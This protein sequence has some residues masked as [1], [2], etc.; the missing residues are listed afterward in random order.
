VSI[1]YNRTVVP[2]A[3]TQ[4]KNVISILVTT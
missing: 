4:L 2:S 3:K 1:K